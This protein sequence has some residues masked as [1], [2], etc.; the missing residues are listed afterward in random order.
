VRIRLLAVLA[1]SG[2]QL[3]AGIE[4]LQLTGVGGPASGGAG[5]GG[6][7]IGASGGTGASGGATG[8]DIPQGMLLWEERFEDTDFASR[9][10]Y[11]DQSGALSTDAAEGQSSLECLLDAG[12]QI[13]T[14]GRPGRHPVPST[15]RIYVSFHVRRS[16][17]WIGGVQLTTVLTNEDD[18]YVGP[19]FTH[20][21]G[22]ADL[23]DDDAVISFQDGANVDTACILLDDDSFLGCNGDF[24]SYVFDE[25]RSAASCNG[26]IGD[27]ELFDCGD[28]DGDG[29]YWSWRGWS[30]GPAGIDDAWHHIEV[31]Y[32]MSSIADGIGVADGKLRW[33]QDGVTLVCKDEVLLRTGAHAAQR[34]DQISLT[35]YMNT[36]PPGPQ[37][38]LVDHLVVATGRP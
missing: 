22:Y 36:P 24:D 12:A 4:D 1:L 35:L 3:F 27:V 14:G 13:C 26:R 28:S 25:D 5:G 10:W 20:F 15:D 7:G 18:D 37:T 38:L 23:G 33:V 17:G 31:Y 30:A 32:E 29:D 9:G 11:D 21:S 16:A 34:F 6:G 2:C 8:C 19:G